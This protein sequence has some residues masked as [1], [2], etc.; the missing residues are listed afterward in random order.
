[1]AEGQAML[2][3]KGDQFIQNGFDCSNRSLRR[4]NPISRKMV[5]SKVRRTSRFRRCSSA[6]VP[7]GAVHPA[8]LKTDGGG[9][10][11][12]YGTEP[13][14]VV[15]D[16]VEPVW[17]DVHEEAA[18]KLV[19]LERYDLVAAGPL[20]PVVL[21]PERDA[22]R[23]GGDE[24]A[25]GDRDPMRVAGQIGQHLLGAGERPLAVDEPRGPMQWREIGLERGLVGEV[26]MIAEELQGDRRRA[27]RGASPASGG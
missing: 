13:Q 3:L 10:K 21:V 11:V 2:T 9:L 17:Q 1:M 19:R 24:P 15:P 7:R 27:R 14:T 4:L 6:G 23:V 25:V 12:K 8:K 16:P 26:G 5:S 18:D 22:G 20:D